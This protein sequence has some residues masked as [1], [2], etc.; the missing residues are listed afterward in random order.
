MLCRFSQYFSALDCLVFKF[1]SLSFT[2]FK[3]PKTWLFEPKSSVL[4]C[5]AKTMKLCIWKLIP[6][7]VFIDCVYC[8]SVFSARMML[9]ARECLWTNGAPSSKPDWS[10]LYQDLTVSTHTSTNWV[11]YTQTFFFPFFFY[12]VM[13][14]HLHTHTLVLFNTNSPTHKP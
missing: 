5:K 10:A 2:H 11:R 13:L 7:C 3:H 14:L 9:A 1:N 12:K 6:S 4:E 8:I